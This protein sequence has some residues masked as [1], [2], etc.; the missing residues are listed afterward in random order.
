M[1]VHYTIHGFRASFSSWC[2]DKMEFPEQLVEKCLAHQ[3][4]KVISAYRRTDA[5]E[6]RREIMEAW[7]EYCGTNE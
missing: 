5:L 2:Y 1:D 6:R 4:S 3:S 7:A